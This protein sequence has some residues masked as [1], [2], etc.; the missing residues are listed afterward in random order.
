MTKSGGSYQLSL[1]VPRISN[2][3]TL[4][5][6]HLFHLMHPESP[7][8][9]GGRHRHIRF[10][11]EVDP[12]GLWQRHVGFGIEQGE[13]GKSIIIVYVTTII[14]PSFPEIIPCATVMVKRHHFTQNGLVLLAAAML[15]QAFQHTAAEWM[16]ARSS[17]AYRCSSDIPFL[18]GG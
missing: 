8:Q 10:S 2:S 15:Q 4:R 17:N 5:Q 16:P 9:M 7:S 13:R 3:S 14:N 18:V 6:S 11:V 1:G 12:G